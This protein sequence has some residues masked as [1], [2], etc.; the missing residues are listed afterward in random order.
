M[1][2]NDIFGLTEIKT[3]QQDC[4]LKWYTYNKQK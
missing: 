4:G 2:E 1:S 3:E